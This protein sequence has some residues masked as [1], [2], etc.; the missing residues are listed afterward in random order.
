[1]RATLFNPGQPRLYFTFRHRVSDPGRFPEPR[2]AATFIQAGYAHLH[3]QARLNDWYVN[4]ETPELEACLSRLTQGMEH[5]AAMGFLM[6]GYAGLR[7]ARELNLKYLLAVSPQFSISEHHVPFDPRFK[8]WATDFDPDLGALPSRSYPVRGLILIDP[9]NRADL[10]NARMVQDAFPTM[11]IVRL[12]FTGHPATKVIRQTGGYGR[13]QKMLL[14]QRLSPERMVR[15][16]RAARLKSPRYWARLAAAAAK[17]GRPELENHAQK[18]LG[19]LNENL[20]L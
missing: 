4:S 19:E 13:L 16:H 5:V 11:N 10:L 8:K 9:F 18:R 2:P 1:M 12:C 15:V 20:V 7:L 14:R 3:V 6:R 17:T